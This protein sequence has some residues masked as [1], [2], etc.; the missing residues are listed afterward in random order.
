MILAGLLALCATLVLAACSSDPA[1]EPSTAPAEQIEP[2]GASAPDDAEPAPADSGDGV[3]PPDDGGAGADAPP[4]VEATESDDGLVVDCGR[5]YGA[6]SPWNTLIGPDPVYD[7]NSEIYV[8]AI[9]DRLTS[10]PT[11]FTFPVYEVTADTPRLD[12]EITGWFS[13]V[14]GD[15]RTMQNNNELTIQIPIPPEA[16]PAAGDD[17]Q[18]ILVDPVTGDEWGA[19]HFRRTAAGTYVAEN[20]YHYNTRWDAVPPPSTG[21]GVFVN[22]GAG[23]PYLAGLV[24]PC[25]IEVG[26]ID[27]ALAFAFDSPSADYVYPATKSDGE[28]RIGE[29]PPEG[30]RLQL[31]PTLTEADLGALG[32]ADACLTVARAL[33]DYGM[34]AI[35]NSGRSKVMFEYIGTANWNG[36]VDENTVSPIPLDR[37]RVIDTR[38]VPEAAGCTITGTDADDVLE[39]TR[40]ADV[41]CGLAG[42]DEI[43][44]LDG[45]DV[46]YGGEGD[47]TIVGGA[48]QDALSG[49]AGADAVFGGSGGDVIDAGEGEDE[50]A[51]GRG[52]DRL[53]T[54]DGEADRVDGGPGTDEASLD[55]SD[56]S[57]G[58]E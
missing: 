47:D 34:I 45:N 35:D 21:G 7:R 37:F 17:S 5:P 18:V 44:G 46:I 3:A 54:D 6:A 14:M 36:V 51:G 22:R 56:S 27:H 52:N 13:N 10:D 57:S 28:G 23:L 4:A 33:Q 53:L 58:V 39:G 32:C 9:G 38:T 50:V 26:Q 11:Q 8:A 16:E 2:D 40:S 20:A 48:G 49:G 15:G 25:E 12:V 55:P 24:R 31:D 41:I 30:A 1:D 43:R 19:W 42:D 29:T